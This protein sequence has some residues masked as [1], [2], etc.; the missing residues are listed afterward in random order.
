MKLAAFLAMAVLFNACA[1]TGKYLERCATWKGKSKS[2]L[3]LGWGPPTNSA[4]IDASSEW[5][6]F[7][8]TAGTVYNTNYGSLL[9]GGSETVTAYCRTTFLIKDGIV[10]GGKIDGNACRAK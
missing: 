9:A 5:V 8:Q 1:T 4:Q 2:E 3:I 6:E 10:Q 7:Y